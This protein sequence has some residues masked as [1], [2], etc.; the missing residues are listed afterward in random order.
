LCCIPIAIEVGLLILY[1][2]ILD[3]IFSSKNS[4][5]RSSGGD[6]GIYLLIIPFL[7]VFYYVHRVHKLQRDLI[8]LIIARV[9]GWIY[10]PEE[11]PSRWGSFSSRFP[12][13]FL[14]GNK[15]QNL[16][17]EFWGFYKT[18]AITLVQAQ[19]EAMS[20]VAVPAMVAPVAPIQAPVPTPTATI[21][22]QVAANVNSTPASPTVYKINVAP[23]VS[24]APAKINTQQGVPFYSSVFEYTVESGGGRRRHST[25]YRKTVFAL[26]L[27]KV[28][29]ADFRLEPEGIINKFLNFF[30]KKEINTES[31]EFNKT[32]AFFYGGQKV[33]SELEIVKTLSPAVQ[34][35]L[36]ELKNKRGG[37]TIL[38]R[39]DTVFVVFEGNLFK[40]M[41]TSFFKSIELDPRDHELMQTIIKEILDITSQIIPYLD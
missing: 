36:L 13:L 20:A 25:T 38:F 21:A 14:K 19:A 7:P 3:F 18:T 16:Q 22:P 35:K 29:K 31:A 33:D 2:E 6:N 12:E 32:F 28:I 17:D 34:I 23:V 9:N 41:Y 10:S 30:R 8:K 40:K 39:G 5:G 27:N 24:A 26:R 1:P 4:R 37:F 15:K 11:S